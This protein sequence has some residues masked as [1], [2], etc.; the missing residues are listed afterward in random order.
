MKKMLSV[1]L[2]LVI[3]YT[4]T[5]CGGN[6]DESTPNGTEFEKEAPTDERIRD[7]S[8]GP[9]VESESIEGAK[10][11]LKIENE[12]FIFTM[13]DNPTSRDF[14]SKLPLT[15]SF[16]DFGGFEKMSVLE[17]GLSMEDAPDGNTPI[18]GDFAYYAPWK[19]VTIFYE[20]RRY[21][22]GLIQ[23]GKIESSLDELAKKLGGINADFI[24][25]MEN[26]Q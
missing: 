13:Y 2:A 24:V 3:V 7:R 21:S 11:R 15:L 4:L 16:E 19:V 20:N 9:T 5:G 18:A 8:Q 10:I 26:M 25:T 1:T 6:E 14:L 22:P 12:D 23:L 17:E